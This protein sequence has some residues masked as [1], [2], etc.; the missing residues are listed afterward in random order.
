MSILPHPMPKNPSILAQAGERLKP[1]T[2]QHQLAPMRPVLVRSQLRGQ[3][4]RW[5]EAKP[6]EKAAANP[7]VLIEA[8]SRHQ[9]CPHPA[10]EGS[11]GPG[12]AGGP[13]SPKVGSPRGSLLP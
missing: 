4:Q 3:A 6:W 2:W 5:G 7:P 9:H 1:K 12:Q 11:N 10:G 8:V 13:A